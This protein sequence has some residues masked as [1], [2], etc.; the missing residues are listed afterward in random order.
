MNNQGPF[1]AIVMLLAV[2]GTAG[3][4]LFLWGMWQILSVVAH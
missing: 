4:L 3:C 2:L 1:Q